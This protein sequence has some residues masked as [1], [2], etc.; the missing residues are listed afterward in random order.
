MALSPN[1][2]YEYPSHQWRM[3]KWIHTWMTDFPHK[4]L[5]KQ[6][7]C[8]CIIMWTK[9]FTHFDAT[10]TLL[11]YYVT[12]GAS[13]KPHRTH[14]ATML[15]DN[16]QPLV[17]LLS[18][19]FSLKKLSDKQSNYQSQIQWWTFL[20]AI[21][22]LCDRAQVTEGFEQ[23]DHRRVNK[24]WFASSESR[25]YTVRIREVNGYDAIVMYHYTHRYIMWKD[26]PFCRS[27][28]FSNIML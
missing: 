5:V 8:Y 1:A 20:T 3:V 4:G 23:Y 19:W 16:F 11:S 12:A 18:S 9:W 10:I 24:G 13:F 21:Q 7:P 17:F 6:K 15:M 2:T 22:F 27:T 14:R 25:N 28:Y 26:H